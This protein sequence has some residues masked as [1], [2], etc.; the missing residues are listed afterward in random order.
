MLFELSIRGGRTNQTRPEPG[1]HVTIA[2][3]P[4]LISPDGIR[5]KYEIQGE[6]PPLLLHLGAGCDSQLWRA[7]GYLEPLSNSYRC[8]LFDHRGHGESDRPRGA[9][10]HHLDRYT[11][12][13]LALL[14]E[15][16]IEKCA[17]WGYSAGIDVGLKLAD[18]H[19]VRIRALVGSGGL[20]ETTPEALAEMVAR[21]VSE[22]REHGWKKLID[23]FDVNERE[24][25]PEWMK[26]RIRATD[27]EQFIGYLE[28][29]RNWTWNDWEALPRVA[30]PT[31][32][33]TGELED[34]EDE[35]QVAV[36]RMPNARRVRLAGL[37]HINA[38]LSS[39]LVLPHVTEFLAHNTA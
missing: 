18:D 14:D 4:F 33:L 28:S 29:T 3:M 17:F 27:I 7:A 9:E 2:V 30:A 15:L 34:P 6:G 13:V 26:E 1:R 37:G 22:F 16:E 11:A 5:L 36:A 21:R 35:T 20:G 10:A 12:D 31:L 25:V 38:F 8:I 23:R 32:I 19:S 24:P 39:A